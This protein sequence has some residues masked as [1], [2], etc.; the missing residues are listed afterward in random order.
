MPALAA[1]PVAAP[2]LACAGMATSASA[3]LVADYEFNDSLASTVGT[4]PALTEVGVGG[5]TY[6]TEAV[7]R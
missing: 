3:A 6:A 5:A 4:A 1:A 7:F 2:L